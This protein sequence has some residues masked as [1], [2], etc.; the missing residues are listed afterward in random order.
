MQKPRAL[1]VASN[2]F[3]RTR[4][5]LLTMTSDQCIGKNKSRNFASEQIV[6][7]PIRS[8]RPQPLT[9]NPNPSTIAVF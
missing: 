3:G 2:D 9:K 7:I 4:S 5:T 6:T 8:E 1:R